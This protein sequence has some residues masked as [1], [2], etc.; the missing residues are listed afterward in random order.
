MLVALALAAYWCELKRGDLLAY[1]SAPIDTE[2]HCP[3]DLPA[4]DFDR[5]LSSSMRVVV[6]AGQAKAQAKADADQWQFAIVAL[7][8]IGLATSW[9]YFGRSQV[10]P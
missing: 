7:S 10:S 2:S 6:A 5:C 9:I 3:T 1:A 8:L 4:L